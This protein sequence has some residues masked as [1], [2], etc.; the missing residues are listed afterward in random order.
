MIG[1]PYANESFS[2]VFVVFGVFD[3]NIP[4]TIFVE[5]VCVEEFK[6]SSFAVAADCLLGETSVRV[7]TLRVFVK[8]FHVWVRWRRVLRCVRLKSREGS[9]Q[10]SSTIPW[11]LRRGFLNIRLWDEIVGVPWCPVTPKSR[12]LRIGSFSFQNAKDVQR[13]WW[14]SLYP[15]IPSS[16]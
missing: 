15:P 4:V 5:T 12:S 16:P 3:E 10:D 6:F 13:Y 7:F 11:H 14:V 8:I 9:V 2:L 1:S